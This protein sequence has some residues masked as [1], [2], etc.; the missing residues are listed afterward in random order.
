MSKK[1]TFSVAEISGEKKSSRGDSY[2]KVIDS[3]G[4]AYFLWGDDITLLERYEIE[5]G[6]IVTATIQPG[7]FP[8]IKDFVNIRRGKAK[9]IP[10]NVREKA[11]RFAIELL[12]YRPIHEIGLLS[13]LLEGFEEYLKTGRTNRLRMIKAVA[14]PKPVSELVPGG[15]EIEQGEERETIEEG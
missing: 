1:V 2:V 9:A 7:R 14:E 5:E 13:D 4:N 3:E 6:D 15:E 12:R 8:R 11:I 10:T